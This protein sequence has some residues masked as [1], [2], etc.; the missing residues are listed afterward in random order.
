MIRL[1]RIEARSSIDI[2][3]VDIDDIYFGYRS[4]INN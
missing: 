2:K 4:E 3:K 1:R